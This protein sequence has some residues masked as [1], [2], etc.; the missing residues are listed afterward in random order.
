MGA[1]DTNLKA[2]RC[3][4]NDQLKQ[5]ER[6]VQWLGIQGLHKGSSGVQGVALPEALGFY[7]IPNV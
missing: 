3:S 2:M 5:S 7:V 4:I 6:I 1:S